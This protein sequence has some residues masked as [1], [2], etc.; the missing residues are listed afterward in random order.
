MKHYHR[1]KKYGDPLTTTYNMDG[2]TPECLVGGCTTDAFSLGMCQKHYQRARTGR[3]LTPERERGDGA[4]IEGYVYLVRHVHPHAR[5]GGYV[6]EHRLVMER[7]IGRYLRPEENVH[8]IN[9]IRNDNRPENLELWTVSQ[10]PGQR[11]VDKLA[12]AREI[13]ELYAPVESHLKRPL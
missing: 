12:W 11:A 6:A 2:P 3:P 5:K 9:G 8:H 1:W 10:P 4:D 13:I 7:I